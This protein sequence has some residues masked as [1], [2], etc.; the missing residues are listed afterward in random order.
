MEGDISENVCKLYLNQN[1]VIIHPSQFKKKE[2]VVN[3]AVNVVTDKKKT[4]FKG[5]L[6]KEVSS[7]QKLDIKRQNVVNDDKIGD[8]NTEDQDILDCIQF[9]TFYL[10]NERNKIIFLLSVMNE[11]REKKSVKGQAELLGAISKLTKEYYE[12]LSKVV[13]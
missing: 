13:R 11:I 3:Y 2:D 4:D 1:L 5:G 6:K 8:A 7:T 10:L 12:K 9:N